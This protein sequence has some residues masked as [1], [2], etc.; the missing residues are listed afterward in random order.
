MS[1]E[2]VINELLD[3]IKTIKDIKRKYKKY[4][5]IIKILYD[6]RNKI[7][8]GDIPVCNKDID[9]IQ[10]IYDRVNEFAKVER[11]ASDINFDTGE[12][13]YNNKYNF[14]FDSVK[15]EIIEHLKIFLEKNLEENNEQHNFRIKVLISATADKFIEDLLEMQEVDAKI[16]QRYK[17]KYYLLKNAYKKD[18][19]IDEELD[20]EELVDEENEIVQ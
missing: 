11:L 9:V 5:D 14:V 13:K 16:Y 18:L 1:N 6:F 15:G 10:S 2:E 20:I 3:L 17:Q 12:I 7:L 8:M 19:K 4:N